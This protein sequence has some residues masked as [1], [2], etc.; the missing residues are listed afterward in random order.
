MFDFAAIEAHIAR[1][2]PD[3]DPDATVTADYLGI[4]RST[5][6][7][8]RRDG[9]TH[10]IADRICITGLGVH[11]SFIYPQWSKELAA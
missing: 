9:M 10:N 7:A 3:L 8:L 2:R 6:Y 11:P 4:S 5:L 1:T